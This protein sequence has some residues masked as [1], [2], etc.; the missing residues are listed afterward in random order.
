MN[1]VTDED[2]FDR[3]LQPE[4]TLLA[5][6]RTTLSAAVIGAVGVRVMAGELGWPVV[7]VGGLAVGLSLLAYLSAGRR[8]RHVH[9]HLLRTNTHAGTGWPQVLLTAATMLCGLA[10]LLWAVTS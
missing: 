10:A 8:Y 6:R 1:R 4:R 9:A 2:V 7:I 5:W 3:G